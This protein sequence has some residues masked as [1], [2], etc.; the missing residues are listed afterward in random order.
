MFELPICGPP[1]VNEFTAVLYQRQSTPYERA[2]DVDD[3]SVTN[4]GGTYTFFGGT[5]PALDANN[6]PIAGASIDLTALER[7]RRTLLFQNLGYSAAEIRAL[8]GGASQFSLSTGTPS[9]SVSQLDAGLFINDDWRIRPNLTLSYGLR[10]EVQT[11]VSDH[12]DWSPRIGIAWGVDGRGG[13]GAKTVVRLGFGTFYDRIG[14]TRSCPPTAMT[15]SHSS[16]T[17]L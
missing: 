3:T 15:A 17:W 11:N 1:S 7:Y 4:F 14:E 16:R 8:G 12:G 6:Q 10:Y 9:L 2:L 5:G 13:K